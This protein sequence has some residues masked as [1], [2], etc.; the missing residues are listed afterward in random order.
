MDWISQYKTDFIQ[1]IL[2]IKRTIFTKVSKHLIRSENNYI[3]V[4]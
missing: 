2:Y 3:G 4:I 1:F